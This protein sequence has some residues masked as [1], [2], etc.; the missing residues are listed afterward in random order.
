MSSYQVAPDFARFLQKVQNLNLRPIAYQL[1]QSR[2][3]LQWSPAQAAKA[4]T[5]YIAFLYL[6]D[7]YPHLQ[8]VPTRE[9]DE[10][11]HQHILDTTKYAEDCQ[12]LFGRFIHHFPYLGTRGEADRQALLKAYAITLVL[13][14]KHFGSQM[15]NGFDHADCEPLS[16]FEGG[17]EGA[18]CAH[19]QAA[20]IRPEVAIDLSEIW[21]ES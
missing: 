13:F 19:T 5:R 1:T 4:I 9:I 11:W 2:S 21:S 3:G 20:Q 16:L 12:I 10:V 7:R 6:V 18:G 14:R 15:V 17:A 8:L